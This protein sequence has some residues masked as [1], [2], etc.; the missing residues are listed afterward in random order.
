MPK[1]FF[2]ATRWKICDD[3][4]ER[5]R[6]TCSFLPG[7]HLR[8][9]W[10]DLVQCV[11]Y[12]LRKSNF[13]FGGFVWGVEKGTNFFLLK[14]DLCEHI[15]LMWLVQWGEPSRQ[16]LLLA[17]LGMVLKSQN[18]KRWMWV[19]PFWSRKIASRWSYLDRGKY[20]EPSMN[21]APQRRM[22]QQE[23]ISPRLKTN[24]DFLKSRSTLSAIL[25]FASNDGKKWPF[26]AVGTKIILN[27]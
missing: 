12:L 16:P 13:F 9:Q 3:D 21:T 4:D 20:I 17:G 8:A 2:F 14:V 19:Q 24:R 10:L 25:I 18:P 27:G 1:T 11:T 22:Y 6:R 26:W 15:C 23:A 7:D 5:A